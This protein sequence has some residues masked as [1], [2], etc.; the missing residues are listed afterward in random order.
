MTSARIG[1]IVGV[2]LS[3]AAFLVYVAILHEPGSAFYAFAGLVFLGFPLLAGIVAISRAQKSKPRRFF[4]GSGLVFGT[5]ILLFI[6]TYVVLPMF[7]RA[8]VQLPASCNGF[9]GVL[10]LPSRARYALPSGKAAILLA[11]S[12]ESAFAAT[13]DGDRAPYAS[14]VYLVRKSDRAILRQMPFPDDVV[15]ASIEAGTVY[16]Y[17]DKLG[18]P[19]DE[20]T[21]EFTEKILLIDNYGGLSETD[22]PIIGGASSGKWY[23]ETTA[24]ISTWRRDGTVKSRAHLT[25]NGI[26]R[27]CYV[28]G[29]TGEVI[30]LGPAR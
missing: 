8:S 14:T 25:M 6:V 10:D 9:H 28:S 24:V 3:G 22:R 4:V 11:E 1:L 30:P 15:V 2:L 23:L 5:T 7:D 21:G 17:N 13:V 29:A 12:A 26:A 18:Y 27:G 19:I 16:L 20:R